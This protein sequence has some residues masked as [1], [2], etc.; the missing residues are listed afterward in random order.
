MVTLV[1]LVELSETVNYAGHPA[2]ATILRD[3]PKAAAFYTRAGK[4]VLDLMLA[5]AALP[6]ALPLIA[7]ACLLVRRDGSHALFSH[8]RVGKNGRHFKC[9]KIRSMVPD[10]ERRLRRHLSTNAQAAAE[11][12]RDHKLT[13]DPRITRF[14]AFLRKSSIDELPQLWNVIRGDMSIVGP[15]PIV[16]EELDKYGVYKSGYLAMKPGIT[17]LWQVSGRNDVSY[18]TRVQLDMKYFALMTVFLDMK[19]I[20]RTAQAVLMRTGK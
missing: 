4:R 20:A 6:F 1:K 14:G 9:W 13:N 10:A 7:A 19:I 18:E 11:W 17:G 15:R 16:D 3:K 12:D 5:F 2:L 8:I